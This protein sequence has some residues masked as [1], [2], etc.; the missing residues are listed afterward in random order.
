MIIK[1]VIGTLVL[2]SAIPIYAGTMGDNTAPSYPWFASIGT[3]YSWTLMPGINNPNQS[4]W[5]FATQGY[6]SAIGDRGFYSFTIGKQVHNYIDLSLMYLAHENFNY[7]KFQSGSS[8][9]PAFTGNQRNR[10]FNLN[11]R[12]L[13]VN[14][15]I[16]PASAIADFAHFG[17]NPYIGAGIGYARN[18]IDNFY[19]IGTTAVGGPTSGTTVNVGSTDSIGSPV[20]TNSF[21]WQGTAAVNIA[22][23]NSHFSVNT[24][25]R[26]YYGGKFN[27][28]S[29]I[30]TNANGFLSAT[31]WSGSIKANQYFVEFQYKV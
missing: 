20:G 10:Y 11:N 31:P 25:Y 23:Q 26:Y 5:D 8:A 29:N 9:T 6:D 24:G 4:Q 15:Y 27:G 19:T 3:G 7:Q 30:Y 16:H 22:S 1:K 18:Y 21:A 28:S 14:A 2:A 13:L 12:S 17:F